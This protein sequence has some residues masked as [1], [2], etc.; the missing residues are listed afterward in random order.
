V[1]WRTH[2][3]IAVALGALGVHLPGFRRRL[4]NSLD[5]LD[6]EI[7]KFRS[8]GSVDCSCA[9]DERLDV[10]ALGSTAELRQLTDLYLRGWT[11]QEI[12]KKVDSTKNGGPLDP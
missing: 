5:N 10:D 1:N 7:R 9:G 4:S 12:E 11:S 6:L 3:W 8:A 2:I